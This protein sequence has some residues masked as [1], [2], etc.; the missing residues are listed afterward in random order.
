MQD[1]RVEA[2]DRTTGACYSVMVTTAR[3]PG[4]GTIAGM[5]LVGFVCKGRGEGG[6]NESGEGE[7]GE[8]ISEGDNSEHRELGAS[9]SKEG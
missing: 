9:V 8:V 5:Q 2:Q 6:M 4:Y 1:A 7:S 3:T